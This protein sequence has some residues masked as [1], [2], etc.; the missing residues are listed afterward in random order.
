MKIINAIVIRICTR[1]LNRKG[2]VF[3]FSVND[4]QNGNDD[5]NAKLS[6]K[7]K[8]LFSSEA[9]LRLN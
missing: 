7:C 2:K 3:S 6:I 4:D 8:M 1:K 5:N 9:R